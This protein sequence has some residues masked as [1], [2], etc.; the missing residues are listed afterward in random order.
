MEYEDQLEEPPGSHIRSPSLTEIH[1][2]GWCTLKLFQVESHLRFLHSLSLTHTHTHTH[3]YTHTNT[4]THTHTH[5]KKL[6]DTYT[7]MEMHTRKTPTH[8]QAQK[9]SSHTSSKPEH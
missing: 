9:T 6:T 2:R 1:A 5:T 3:T 4:H 8:I 7:C